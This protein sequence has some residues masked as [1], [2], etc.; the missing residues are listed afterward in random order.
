MS[1]TGW[2]D[3]GRNKEKEVNMTKNLLKDMLLWGFI[4]W[5]FGY[6]LGIVFFAIVPP[7]L[8]GWIIFPFGILFTFIVV[9][10][11]I[12]L[13]SFRQYVLLAVGWT[14]IAVLCD[15]FFLVK[16]FKPTDGYYKLD[17]YL[18]YLLTFIIPLVVGW[19]KSLTRSNQANKTKRDL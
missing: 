12:Q 16:I 7:A 13:D 9:L 18:Y 15:Y 19:S 8:I 2:K 3:I 10:N 14:L 5:F 17:V 11:K 6:L 1:S 4:L